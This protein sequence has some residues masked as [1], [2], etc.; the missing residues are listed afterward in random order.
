MFHRRPLIDARGLSVGYRGAPAVL[1]DLIRAHELVS[2][3][4]V[5]GDGKPFVA[6]L[7]TV[8]PEALEIWKERHGKSGSLEELVRD[9]EL[10]AEIQGAVDGAN[11]AVSRAEAVRK[12]AVLDVDWTEGTGDLTPTLKLKRNLVMRR[13]YNEVEALYL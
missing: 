13:F 2:Q 6:A 9:A 8:D 12:F 11:A 1:E 10:L 3:T 7:I 5:V 4:M